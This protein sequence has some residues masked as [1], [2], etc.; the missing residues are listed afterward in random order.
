MKAQYLGVVFAAMLIAGVLSGCYGEVVVREPPPADREEVVE[1]APY[2]D[3]VWIPGHWAWEGQYVWVQGTW[4]RPPHERATW[5][6]GHWAQRSG[7]WM[8]I[9]GHWID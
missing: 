6:R 8:W 4:R 9:E 1:A 7:G 3:Y 5:A 2:P